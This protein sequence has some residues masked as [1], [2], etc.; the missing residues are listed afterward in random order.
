M[1]SGWDRATPKQLDQ[2]KRGTWLDRM[3]PPKARAPTEAQKVQRGN[4]PFWSHTAIQCTSQYF[5]RA[6]KNPFSVLLGTD[7]DG[8]PYIEPEQRKMILDALAEFHGFPDGA[9][10]FI[11]NRVDLLNGGTYRCN[12]LW[13]TATTPPAVYPG[14]YCA[15]TGI[16]TFT[17]AD[18]GTSTTISS[19]LA[20][21]V[22]ADLV[23]LD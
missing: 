13:W 10:V 15:A 19:E 23:P 2:M 1:S 4:L 7:A 11:G 8:D 3:P 22:L 5:P 12:H 16:L 17:G 20:P 14:V 21:L 18:E 6:W 9:P